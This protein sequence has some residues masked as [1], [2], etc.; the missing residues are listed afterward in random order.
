MELQVNFNTW[1]IL[2]L[3]AAS[4]GFFLAFI[5][6]TSIKEQKANKYLSLLMIQLG[7]FE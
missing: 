5:L 3:L 7:N 6:F 1:T 4:Q 2:F